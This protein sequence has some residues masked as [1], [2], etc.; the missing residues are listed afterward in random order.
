MTRKILLAAFAAASMSAF[1]VSGE[2]RLPG[3][4]SF[5]ID[6]ENLYELFRDP[7]P[8][9]RPYARWWWN[10]L[11]LDENEILRELDIMKEMGLGGVEINSIRFP[12]EADTLGYKVMPYLSDDWAR[13]VRVA[14]DGCRDRG[15]VCDMIGGSGWPFGGEFLPREH[16]LQ[17]LTVETQKVDGG[18]DGT[19][20]TV[21]RDEILRRVDPPIMSR[22]SDPAK[23]LMYIRLMPEKVDSFTEGVDYDSLAGE[24]DIRIEVPAGKHII[25]F[26]VKMTGYMN[27]IEGAPGA[28]GPVL[29]HFDKDAVLNYLERLSDCIGFNSPQMKGLVRAAFVDS[30][31]LEGANWS[32]TLLQE[33][34]D[35]YGYSLM[36]YLPYVIR[37]VGTMGDPLPEDYGCE[38]SEEVKEDVIY[39]VRS[40]FEHFQIKLFQEN[41]IETFNAWCH[42]N[43]LKSRIQAYGRALHPIETSMYIDIPECETWFRDGLGTDYPDKDIFFGHAHS[44]INKFVASGSL[45]SGNG[46]VSCEEITNTGEIFQ[47]TLEEIKIAGDMSNISGVNSS[48]LHGFNYSPQGAG[49]PGWVKFGEYFSEQNTM[50]PYYRL[51]TDYKARISAVLQNSVPQSDVAILPPLEDMWSVL[52]QQRDPYPVNVYPDYAHDLWQNL[53][54]NGNGCD[55]ISEN[56]IRQAKVRRGSLSFG[57]RSY[58][59][60]ILMEVESMAPETALMLEKFVASGGKVLCIGKT[61]YQSIGFNDYKARSAKVR[62]TVERIRSRYPDRFLTTASPEGSLTEWYRGVQQEFGITPYVKMDNP[63]KWVFCNYYKSGDRDIFFITNFNRLEGHSFNAVFPESVSGKN[64]WIW[65]PETGM[66]YRLPQDGNRMKVDL[67]PS[68]S[69]FIVFDSEDGG[70]M[71]SPMPCRPENAFTLSGPWDVKAEHVDGS[72]REFSMDRLV[73]FNTLPFPWLRTFAGTVSYTKTVDVTD[74][75]A[76]SVLDAGKVRGI[77]ELYVNGVKAGVCWYGDHRFDI[78]GLLKAGANTLTLKVV[79]PLGNYADSLVENRTAK[80]YAHT[81]KSL[82]LEEEVKLY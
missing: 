68:E 29:N 19:V 80:R 61:P 64:A 10:G 73:D 30:F 55:Y 37:K 16:Q 38:F 41:F 12:D 69:R 7:A 45:L 79:T 58:R 77:T 25:Y 48:I 59:T 50:F 21:S 52:G 66:R 62:E 31:E 74:P 14:A 1:P 13:M 53:H 70:Q 32:D 34:E 24:D 20:F 26:F 15:M 35:Y 82:G 17:M 76:F 60:V 81:M 51:W 9:Y 11:R 40:D 28:C 56:I 42:R 63:V 46:K 8:Q 5:D 67:G 22:N 36:P 44:M 4:S 2:D 57:P 23:E 78:G 27:V 47:S 39:R 18:S 71:Y 54:Q 49:F 3:K 72:S 6:T 65:I 43:G 33:W 75:E